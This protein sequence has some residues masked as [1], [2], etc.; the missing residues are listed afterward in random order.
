[1]PAF[2]VTLAAC[3][4]SFIYLS[5]YHRLLAA[6]KTDVQQLRDE[7]AVAHSNLLQLRDLKDDNIRLAAEL[8]K[9]GNKPLPVSTIQQNSNLQQY[10]A[11]AGVV[12]TKAGLEGVLDVSW[13]TSPFGSDLYLN[14]S[15]KTNRTLGVSLSFLRTHKDGPE[16]T[17]YLQPRADY[18][19][20]R[21]YSSRLFYPGD[22]F[23]V[24]TTN[25][26]GIVV[27]E[28]FVVPMISR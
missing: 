12:R 7:L 18:V 1:M 28:R 19:S 8:E 23:E 3:G 6:H 16:Y 14:L 10:V 24:K 21:D 27:L 15:N 4:I 13:S 25:D 26:A 17:I 9:H 2:L 20:S 11:H 5:H 22:V